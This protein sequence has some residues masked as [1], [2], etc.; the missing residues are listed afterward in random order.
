MR[1]LGDGV[2]ATEFREPASP[3]TPALSPHRAS[4]DALCGERGLTDEGVSRFVDCV[5]SE[6]EL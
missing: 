4:V 6:I 1:H 3:L 5:I 2:G